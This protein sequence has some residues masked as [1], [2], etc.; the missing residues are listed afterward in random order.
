VG[1]LRPRVVAALA[2]PRAAGQQRGAEARAEPLEVAA[3]EAEVAAPV[4]PP[5]VALA[6]AVARAARLAEPEA[7]AA[8]VREPPA[9][10]QVAIA[11]AEPTAAVADSAAQSV[12]RA[13]LAAALP[14]G[15][16]AS[17]LAV[18]QAVAAGATLPA[19]VV[20]PVMAQAVA[21]PFA[22]WAR[23]PQDA[24]QCLAAAVRPAA[25]PKQVVVVEHPAPEAAV[26]AE[27]Q[28]RPHLA[29]RAA[30]ACRDGRLR[31][32]ATAAAAIRTS[33]AE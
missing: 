27:A 7:V 31:P 30:D 22:A 3:A 17:S 6:E 5:A 11:V 1:E 25:A 16:R 4:A 32:G 23:V 20:T 33:R 14:S 12:A 8:R 19:A 21:M 2:E 10:A 29:P 18:A 26:F 15:N 9:V 13:E 28:R 24:D